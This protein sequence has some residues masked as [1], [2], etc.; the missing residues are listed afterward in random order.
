M[1]FLIKFFSIKI[2]VPGLLWLQHSP[3]CAEFAVNKTLQSGQLGATAAKERLLIA[4]SDGAERCFCNAVPRLIL[5]ASC[6]TL[7]DAGGGVVE[8]EDGGG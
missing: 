7:V 1:T 4:A 6:V 5:L 2:F 3:R 8:F